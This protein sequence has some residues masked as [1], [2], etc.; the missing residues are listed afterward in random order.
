MLAERGQFL[1]NQN[2]DLSKC[3]SMAFPHNN[4]KPMTPIPENNDI[5]NPNRS[6][7][8]NYDDLQSKIL[9]NEMENERYQKNFYSYIS[10][11]R[12]EKKIQ[13]Q[14]ILDL[15]NMRKP[16]VI[17]SNNYF[18]QNDKYRVGKIH[19]NRGAD[20]SFNYIENDKGEAVKLSPEKS[21]EERQKTYFHRKRIMDMD[22]NGKNY[23]EYLQG[24]IDRVEPN[25]YNRHVDYLGESKL[26]YNAISN[27]ISNK[28][29][30]KL[31]FGKKMFIKPQ[32]DNFNKS[33]FG[34]EYYN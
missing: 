12:T 8:L 32:V 13:Q 10:Q 19:L 29:E 4:N 24:K 34:L 16:K 3:Q 26:T 15:Y 11:K 6:Q 25:P 17:C 9:L 1:I 14:N 31:L 18:P 7:Q 2:Q 20:F 23:L 22:F 33:P 30:N 28:M 5:I 21:Q 27:P